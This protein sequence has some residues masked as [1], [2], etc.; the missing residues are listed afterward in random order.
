MTKKRTFQLPK[1]RLETLMIGMLV[2]VVLSDYFK[3]HPIEAIT[4]VAAVALLLSW[5]ESKLQPKEG[6][7]VK[8]EKDLAETDQNEHLVRD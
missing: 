7:H 2:G 4:I 8:M 6:W 1:F 3:S 5:Y